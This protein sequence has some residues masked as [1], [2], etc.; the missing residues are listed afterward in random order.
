M[1]WLQIDKYSE[2]VRNETVQREDLYATLQLCKDAGRPL[3]MKPE[4][5]KELQTIMLAAADTDKEPSA[6]SD[7]DTVCELPMFLLLTLLTGMDR[8][9]Y[10]SVLLLLLVCSE[11]GL[12]DL[13]E[14][15]FTNAS[16]C[17]ICNK[18]V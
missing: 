1:V 3:C 13:V 16:V 5:R 14:T 17:L 8:H 4:D 18:K 7:C 2:E 12:H 10:Y 6:R 15:Q 11:G 9:L